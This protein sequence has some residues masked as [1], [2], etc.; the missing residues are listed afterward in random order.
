[1]AE[2]QATEQKTGFFEQVKAFFKTLP[3]RLKGTYVEPGEETA[4]VETSS[5]V[6]PA[7]EA[8]KATVVKINTQKADQQKQQKLKEKFAPKLK[9]QNR[10]LGNSATKQ[11]AYMNGKRP[12]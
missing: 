8:P 11:A 4:K 9:V 3:A 5:V 2:A 1:M 12:R 10:A 7:V 6:A